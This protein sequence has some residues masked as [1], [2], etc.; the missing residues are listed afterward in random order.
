MA[1]RDTGLRILTLHGNGLQGLSV[2]TIVDELCSH[3]AQYNKL[4]HIPK[5]CEIFDVICG[6]GIGAF[7]AVLL[8]RYQVDI[9]QC[10]Q[11]YM[12]FAEYIEESNLSRRTHPKT[13][14]ESDIH[15]FLK[16]L[17]KDQEWPPT[18]DFSATEQT[19]RCHTVV[20]A[21]QSRYHGRKQDPEAVLGMLTSNSETVKNRNLSV[22]DI[23]AA[24]IAQPVEQWISVLQDDKQN[25]QPQL[26]KAHN[27]VLTAVE[28]LTSSVNGRARV[29]FIA[30]VGTA[31]TEESSPVDTNFGL[32]SPV[33]WVQ[34]VASPVK[35]V[36]MWPLKATLRQA[37]SHIRKKSISASKSSKIATHH[38]HDKH[39]DTALGAEISIASSSQLSELIDADRSLFNFC[40]TNGRESGGNDMLNL[41]E[42][43]ANIREI[44]AVMEERRLFADAATQ[45]GN[46]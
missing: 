22:A 37:S 8:A 19:K 38:E 28:R 45:F 13:L 34:D 24:T 21:R 27:L 20:L 32:L 36:V 23:V 16:M 10:K 11:H 3:I 39:E 7:I 25:F 26:P 9:Q 1:S 46:L 2:I 5:P 41:K 31:E 15:D 42:A 43:R 30:S 29:A 44:V 35:D 17:I 4:D 33:F 18:L 12:D 40:S 14:R 6:T